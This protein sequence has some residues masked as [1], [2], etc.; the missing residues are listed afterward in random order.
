V[1][2]RQAATDAYQ[3]IA[4]LIAERRRAGAT[5]QILADELNAEGHTTRRGCPWSPCQVARM[6][7]RLPDVRVSTVI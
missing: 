1:A 2:R 5:L 7:A 4:P 3:D 6:L